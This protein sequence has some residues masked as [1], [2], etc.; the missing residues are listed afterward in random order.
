MKVSIITITLNSASTVRDTLES[1]ACQTYPNIEHVI[2]D[3]ASSDKTLTEVNKYKHLHKVISEPDQ[4]IYDAMNKGIQNVSGDI[5]G[6]LNSDDVFADNN[7]ISKIVRQFKENKS[8]Y[9]VYGNI[10]YFKGDYPEKIKRTWIPKPYYED[11]FEDGEVPPHPTLF[12]RK[13]V[14]DIIGTYYPKFKIASDYEFMLRMLKLH[15][16][17][18]YHLN[19]VL[20]RMR[21]GGDSGSGLHNLILNNNEVLQAWKM[22]GLTPP[23]KFYFKRPVKKIRQLF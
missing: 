15:N 12:V 2:V 4:G 10:T 5:V 22:N 17:K 9:T 18:S 20:V 23:L 3:G 16:Y 19:E 1:V 21:L 11:F 7:V 14:Y 13:E 6:I 8:I